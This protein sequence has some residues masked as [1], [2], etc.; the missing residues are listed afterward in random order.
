MLRDLRIAEGSYFRL[1]TATSSAIT[2]IQGFNLETSKTALALN[3]MPAVMAGVGRAG[4]ALRR[5][6]LDSAQAFG[7]FE[8]ELLQLKF[9]GGL[10][11]REMELLE[12]EIHRV[13]L[14]SSFMPGELANVTRALTSTGISAQI[15]KESLE[16]IANFAQ[17][18]RGKIGL[19]EAA[20]IATLAYSRFG[21]EVANVTV[22]LDRLSRLTQVSR[23][24][25]QD[26]RAFLQTLGTLPRM[27]PGQMNQILAMAAVLRNTLT[28]A[29]TADRMRIFVEGFIQIEKIRK[30]LETFGGTRAR[31][32]A[33]IFAAE[34]LNAQ[35]FDA[36]GNFD[37]L[38]NVIARM[39]SALGG[40]G[41]AMSREV[42]QMQAFRTQASGVIREIMNARLNMADFGED[43][44][45]QVVR[46][47]EA[48]KFLSNEFRNANGLIAE[49]REEAL[50]TSNTVGAI[51]TSSFE[52]FRTVLGSLIADDLKA[53]KQAIIGI[54]NATTDLLRSTGAFGEVAAGALLTTG[55]LLEGAAGL[56]NRVGQ[57]AFSAL[58][59]MFLLRQMGM[60]T[61]PSQMKAVAGLGF[62]GGLRKGLGLL[63]FGGIGGMFKFLRPLRSPWMWWYC[64]RYQ[65]SAAHESEGLHGED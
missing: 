64:C 2:R 18:F 22:L 62:A 13:N 43:L 47:T 45:N 35:L 57:I 9:Q 36:Q 39:E 38:I 52:A 5:G 59:I 49:F 46:G 6:M 29:Q 54:T 61:I 58:S 48:I 65:L 1:S 4:E 21:D 19:S 51:M 56:W 25:P 20:D 44:P 33:K 8:Q 7:N 41:S 40:M 63:S 10:S 16:E 60:T 53:Y 12:E 23:F 31:S 24:Q 28:P 26:F 37:N 55:T 15:A 50:L 17:L 32:L 3:T 42:T 27:L 14:V 30:R 11:A 34:Q